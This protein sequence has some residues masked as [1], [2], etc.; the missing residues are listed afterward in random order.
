MKNNN[1]C[2]SSKTMQKISFSHFQKYAL[3]YI[4]LVIFTISIIFRI[5]FYLLSDRIARD[6]FTYIKYA[7]LLCQN[8]WDW[9]VVY[10]KGANVH[11]PPLLISV[12]ALGTKFGID[13]EM[14]GILFVL[15]LGSLVP[16]GVF[17]CADHIFKKRIYAFFAGMLIAVHPYSIE[18]S[19][20]ILRDAP[21]H[22]FLI[23]SLLAAIYA[24]NSRKLRYWVACGIIAGLAALT[25]RE[26]IELLIIFLVWNVVWLLKNK[27]DFK[28]SLIIVFK[29]LG[30][31]VFCFSLV[32]FPVWAY[33]K[34]T[35]HPIW[36][37]IP[38][39]QFLGG[40]FS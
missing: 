30:I 21:Y 17:L 5:T 14:S 24:I 35:S 3:L 19:A 7:E 9:S 10:V 28:K 37:V 34:Y 2:R 11:F 1:K 23:F 25:R 6:S 22:C 4:T 26:G 31:T 16:V 36:E 27:N 15:M 32:T 13:V 39:M 8:N 33:M 12:M 18:L 38:V 29:Q 40:Y 20:S